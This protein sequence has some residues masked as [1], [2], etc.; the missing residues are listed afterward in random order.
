MYNEI[1]RSTEHYQTKVG[2]TT[3][4]R[5]NVIIVNITPSGNFLA[6]QQTIDK[7]DNSVISEL[8]EL[9]DNYKQVQS[10]IENSLW[11]TNGNEYIQ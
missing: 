1:Y 2:D 3:F 4:P 10:F 7:T 8:S 5:V 11:Y 6:I 9:Y